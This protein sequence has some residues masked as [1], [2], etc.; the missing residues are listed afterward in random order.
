MS[1]APTLADWRA[2]AA[3]LAPRTQLLIDG[4]WRDAADGATLACVNPADGR[5]WARVAAGGSGDVDR[6]VHAARAAFTDR[7]WAGQPPA[8]R[9]RVLAR[10]A[11][12]VDAHRD[13]LALL[14]TLNVGKPIR[15]ALAIDVPATARCLRWYGEAID[16][17][18]DEIAPTADSALALIRREPVGVVG[19]VVP[20]NFPLIMT[21]WKLGPALA[22]G[23]SVVLKPAEQSPLS[24]LR[25]A[26]LALEAGLPPGVLNVVTGYGHTAGRALGLHDDV[27]AIGFTGST[28]VGKLFLQYAGQSNLK[29]VWLECGGKTPHILLADCPDVDAAAT[30]AA[31]GIF[32]NQG[33]MCTAGSRLI[34]DRTIKDEVLEKIIAVGRT[35]APGDPLDPATRLGALVS[36]EQWQRVLDYIDIGQAQGARLALGGAAARGA[37]G[38]Y[39]IEP[40]VF[41][42]VN[43]AMRIAQEEIFG[44]VLSVLAVDGAEQ[45]VRIANDTMYG[46]AAAVWTRDFATAHRV[47]R[48][49]RA[50]L[51]WVNCF[52]AD[53]ITT[54]FGGYKQSGN[55]RDKSLHAFDKYTELKTIWMRIGD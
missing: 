18:Y 3:A 45:A 41:D 34:V 29:R 24:A 48:Q 49:L 6:A 42:G 27:D 10:W 19:V 32:F 21:A 46:L 13:E 16:K 47:S 1:T 28:E 26:E 43:N 9:K 25:L 22:A 4:Q 33:E 44:P 17:L 53:D 50:G 12:L 8:A 20:W 30:A 11:E 38:G 36:K 35:L 39:F 14:E 52:D 15:D 31:W 5:S 7:R 55:G 23:N 40:T 2:R 37:S 51:V 54:P